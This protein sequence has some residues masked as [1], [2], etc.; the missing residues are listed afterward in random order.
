[1]AATV[2][3]NPAPGAPANPAGAVGVD[4]PLDRLRRPAIRGVVVGTPTPASP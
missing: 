2:V 3:G 1:M 4:T